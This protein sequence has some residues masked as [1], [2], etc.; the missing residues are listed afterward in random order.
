[1]V[2]LLKDGLSG[3]LGVVIP[4]IQRTEPCGVSVAD[5]VSFDNFMELSGLAFVLVTFENSYLYIYVVCCW[6]VY[7]SMP[8]FN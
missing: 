6:S 4:T 5:T 8:R 1:M 7:E 2:A 3:S